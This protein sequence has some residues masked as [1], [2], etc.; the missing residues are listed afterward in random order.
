MAACS[1]RLVFLPPF[2]LLLV[3]LATCSGWKRDLNSST[4]ERSRGGERY[5][6]LD[7]DRHRGAC[8]WDIPGVVELQP[9]V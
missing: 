8:W 5:M 4:K 3:R 9:D 7:L 6:K 1:S 2:L